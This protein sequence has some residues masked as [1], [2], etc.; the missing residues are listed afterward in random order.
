MIVVTGGTGFVGAAVV[1]ALVARGE[2]VRVVSRTPERAH[3][4]AGVEL[5]AADVQRPASLRRAFERA[6]VVVNAVTFPGY[7]V[8]V[9]RKGLTFEH[10]DQHGTQSQ[11]AAAREVGVSRFV[12][13]SGVYADED[14][15]KPWYRAKGHA[16]AAVRSAPSW[17]VV[18]PSW[19]YGPRDNSLNRFV[20][21]ARWS[22]VMPVIGDGQQRLQPAYI[23]DVAEVIAEAATTDRFDRA[24][25]E[26]GGPDVLTMD[27]VERALLRAMG[28]RA[29]LVHVP[30]GLLR[31]AGHVAQRLLPI[32][33]I[34]AAAVDFLVQDA[35]ADLTVLRER[36]PQ[37]ALTP[38]RD[39]LARYLSPRCGRGRR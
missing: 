9:P 30:A 4:A 32:P 5:A 8:E 13:V 38:L 11:V 2:R 10:Y 16:E 20:P 7:P 15:P 24:V 34:N 14:S 1:D 36:W 25:V 27:D 22:P 31:L 26:V 19:N 33:P 17:V 18:R 3:V 37:L 29:P 35:V 6:D 12:Y 28:R 21:I 39:G 23:A